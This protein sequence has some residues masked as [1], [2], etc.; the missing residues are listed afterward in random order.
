MSD[1][2]I[3]LKRCTKCGVDKFFDNFYKSKINK[4]GLSSWCKE[5]WY[6][7]SKYYHNKNKATF[8]AE[9]P[10]KPFY[11]TVVGKK[12]NPESAALSRDKY[13]EKNLQDPLFKFKYN[14]RRR[15]QKSIKG[16]GFS[17]KKSTH[18]ILGCSFEVMKSHIERQFK[19]GMSWENVGQWHIDH[20]IPMDCA[21]TE[22]DAISLNHYKN[23]RP[24]WAKDNI[25]KNAKIPSNDEISGYKLKTLLKKVA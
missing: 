6:K 17:K 15:I 14:L 24:L 20:I 8:R 4:S 5:C 9:N 23:L 16:Q 21:K 22:Q 7:K 13:I 2:I 18:E 1:Q 11:K 12:R 10:G 25:S 19:D 3:T